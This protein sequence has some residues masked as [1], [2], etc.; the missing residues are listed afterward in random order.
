MNTGQ[1]ISTYL[2]PDIR[3]ELYRIES[4]EEYIE[5]FVVKG[6]FHANVP[7]D[8]QEAWQTVEYILAHAYYHWP[9]YDEGF[10]KALLIIEMAVKLKAKELDMSLKTKPS[11]KGKIFDK[12]LSVLINEVFTEEHFQF[13]KKDIDRARRIRNHQVHSESNTFSGVVGNKTGNLMLAVN[14]LNDIFKNN[15]EQI[16]LYTESVKIADTIRFLNQ[17]L[18]VLEYDKSSILVDNIF[19]FKVINTNLYLFVNPVRNNISEILSN[20]YDIKPEVICLTEYKLKTGEINGVL[21][22]G[23]KVRIYKT[24]KQENKAIHKKYLSKIDSRSK[25]E[26]E[27]FVYT[28]AQ[29]AAWQ[30]VSLEYENMSEGSWSKSPRNI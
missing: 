4:L 7:D 14:V 22:E 23:N 24:D 12:K 15:E 8:I 17:S 29:N 16:A 21:S 13:L 27:A 11:K 3:W 25:G 9:M 28:L 30:M 6:R 20:H 10:Q 19:D 18:L 1:T 5:Q 26:W 2:V